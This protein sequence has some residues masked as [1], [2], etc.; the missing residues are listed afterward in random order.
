M[1]QE[2]F[3]NIQTV[4][5]E[6]ELK[7]SYLDYA[8]SVII[9]RALPDARDGMK[10]VQRRIL[11]SMFEQ[12][13]LHNKP[14]RKSARIVGDVIGKYH[15][16]GDTAIYDAMVR[17][18]QDFSMRYLLVD[19]Q[20]NFGSIDGDP[21]AAYRYTEARMSKAG[22]EMLAD[23]D[24]D[25]VDFV[26]N[27][28]GQEREPSVLPARLP[29]LLLNGA[30]GI[31]VGMATSIP[32]H[33][34]TE[35]CNGLV[36]LIDDG[37]I[38]LKELMKHIKAPDFPTSG[39]ICGREGILTAYATGRGKVVLRAR[40]HTEDLKRRDKQAIIVTEIP[41]MVNKSTLIEKIA[42]L[43]REKKIEGITDIRDE[44]NREGIRMVLELKAGELPEVILNNLYKH[45]DLQTSFSIIFLAIHEGQPKVMGLKEMLRIFLDHRKAVVVRRTRFELNAAEA[46]AHI[47]EGLKIA[48]DHLD[49]VIQLIRKAPSPTDAKEGLRLKFKLSE[50]QAQA[51]LDLRLQKL[52]SL[53]REKIL[54]EYR[55]VLMEI[56]RL[57]E[58]LGSD[59]LQWALI[60]TEIL[61]E[62]EQ[63][64]DKRRSEIVKP[65]GEFSMED[66][67]S[68]EEMVIT[69]S[70]GGYVK[71]TAL[72]TYRAQKRGGKGRIGMAIR[73]EDF[74]ERMFVASTH[75]YMLVFTNHGRLHWVKVYDIPE[76]SAA[77]KGKA[78]QQLL[79]LDHGEQVAA[80]LSTKDFPEKEYLVFATQRGV[81]K[82]TAMEQ[83]A[84]V[85]QVGIKA[86]EFEEGDSLI[87]V[88]R[89][90]G[91]SKI[92]M[93]SRLGQACLFEESDVRPMGRGAMGVIGMRLDKEDEIIEMDV[94]PS[95]GDILTITEK[96]YGKRSPIAEYR[97]TRR[98]G[99][100]VINVNITEKNGP[101][102]GVK[103]VTGDEQIMVITEQG[104]IIRTS[105]ESI[106]RIG[107]ATQGVRVINLEGDDKVVAVAK[108]PKEDEAAEGEE[109]NG[110][111]N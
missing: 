95:D 101:A 64:G 58:L 90:N 2:L 85:R 107:R 1:T 37:E 88:A 23:I 72:S 62:K 47:L 38:D 35:I 5:I 54:D 51:I 65:I 99:K 78:V 15:P 22:G 13:N 60:R 49:E 29:A 105:V 100:G 7:K 70:H 53:E 92:L 20:G 96:G 36:A 98:G 33:N 106:S 109:E 87:A 84:N 61:A 71:R 83:F 59:K 69:V 46:R 45:T 30:T 102:M 108:L 50:I 77:G 111:P 10:P 14:Y 25:T 94:L 12:G 17:M 68:E 31:A 89:S 24:K 66:L 39:L 91:K 73:D 28:D 55:Q 80:I 4:Q 82:K 44:S 74:V 56:A 16:H 8:M 19:G 86:I 110:K 63:F 26:P 42:D 67:I 21:P 11:Y 3:E 81:I 76:I 43:V 9:G 75:S 79:Q 40:I 48:L 103:F 32:P 41:Y 34:L 93:A 18:A 6:D 104:I 52:T 97:E 27:Y 57:T